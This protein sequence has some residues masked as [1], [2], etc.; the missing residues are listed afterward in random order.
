MRRGKTN[1]I[2]DYFDRDRKLE[3]ASCKLCGRVFSFK[4]GTSVSN[5]INHL[6]SRKGQH[7]AQFRE[8][9]MK[10]GNRFFSVFPG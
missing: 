5:L 10:K 9:F 7:E 2:W 1:P 8:Y 4:A 6:A 3:T